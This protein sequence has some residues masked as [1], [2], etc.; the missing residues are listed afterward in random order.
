MSE[1]H[2]YSVVMML[3]AA[4]NKINYAPHG[5][6]VVLASDYD[7]ALARED[8][9]TAVKIG[10]DDREVGI[11]QEAYQ[12]FLE[13]D[14]VRLRQI[15]AD[16]TNFE[17]L[18]REVV[19]LREELAALKSPG[20]VCFCGLKQTK[21]P[22][23]EAGVPPGYLEVGTVYDCIPCL[24]KSR[25]AWSKKANALQ[26]DLTIAEQR[27][28]ELVELLGGVLPILKMIKGDG[29]HIFLNSSERAALEA[30]LKPAESGASE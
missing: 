13:R 25:R 12:I 27:N 1:V 15:E 23:P 2:R 30:A 11:S 29:L 28:A 8:A 18:N 22:H 10:I 4:G 24:N 14:G 21:N 26:A 7:A 17:V 19:A 6:D 20:P 3:S 5:P 9:L 16:Q